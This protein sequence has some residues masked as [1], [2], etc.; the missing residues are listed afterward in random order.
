MQ[1]TVFHFFKSVS[2][3][4]L[5]NDMS[6]RKGKTDT[7]TFMKECWNWAGVRRDKITLPSSWLQGP[8]I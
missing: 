8:S 7:L 5:K 1:L 4:N 6:D 3:V 2:S